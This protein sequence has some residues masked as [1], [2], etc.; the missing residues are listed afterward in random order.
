MPDTAELLDYYVC[1]PIMG[2]KPG[3]INKVVSRY[4][5]LF[6]VADLKDP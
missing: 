2:G 5:H 3:P 1:Q 4:N 6:A